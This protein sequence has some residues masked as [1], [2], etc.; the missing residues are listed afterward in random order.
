MGGHNSTQ[1]A[2]V[3]TSM[4]NSAVLSAT[5]KC[6]NYEHG[7][8]IIDVTGTGN[9]VDDVN[10]RI[11]FS[12]DANCLAG[13]TQQDTLIT[14][15]S[16]KMSQS[17]KDQDLALTQ[18][19]DGSKDTNISKVKQLISNNV[20]S[21]VVQN[22]VKDLDS[23]NILNVAGTGNVVTKI[24]QDST[25]KAVGDC[26]MKQGQT[27]KAV[28]TVTN[29]INQHAEHTSKSPFAFITD[30]IQSVTKSLIYVAA[31]IFIVI[32]CFIGVYMLHNNQFPPLPFIGRHASPHGS[33]P[34]HGTI[35]ASPPHGSSLPH[36]PL[37]KDL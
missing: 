11:S 29:T 30:A 1:V 26:M 18:W 9:V 19:M 25:S 28:E 23:R 8:N 22:C 34:P 4:I 24:V 27:A 33:L 20:S 7:S 37:K 13:A 16:D 32:I 12:I 31:V 17:L 15:M 10:Q 35:H 3:T 21:T 2:N 5:Q 6:I 36:T 14:N